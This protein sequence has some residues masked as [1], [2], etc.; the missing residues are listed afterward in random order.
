ME[1]KKIE[2][3]LNEKGEL[4]MVS[5]GRSMFPMLR[6]KCDTVVIRPVKRELKKYDVV[7]YVRKEDG[8][9]ILH[10]IIGKNENGYIIRGDNCFDKEYGISDDD[11]I[12]ILEEFYRGKRHIDCTKNCF[13]IYSRFEVLLHPVQMW[14]KKI[15]MFFG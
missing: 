1:I 14:A 7:L 9:Y 13:K 10:R 15:K 8:A 5:Q 2:D 3:I 11:V 12:G 6:S 4:V